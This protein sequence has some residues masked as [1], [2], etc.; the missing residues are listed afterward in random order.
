MDFLYDAGLR[1]AQYIVVAFQ[2]RFKILKAL[3]AIATLPRLKM[4]SVPIAPSSIST[5]RSR[6]R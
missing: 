5:R 1:Q 3:A 6:R 2:V 4:K